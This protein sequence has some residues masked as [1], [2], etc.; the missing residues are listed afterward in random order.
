MQYVHSDLCT[1]RSS[2]EYLEKTDIYFNINTH[3]LLVG[4][5]ITYNIWLFSPVLIYSQMAGFRVR[6][7]LPYANQLIQ[8]VATTDPMYGFVQ[9][10]KPEPGHCCRV[11][12]A[13]TP[14][15]CLNTELHCCY[16]LLCCSKS[17][18]SMQERVLIAVRM[19]LFLVHLCLICYPEALSWN[20]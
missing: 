10:R 16:Y 6:I 7:F 5:I 8:L 1:F 3:H 11:S 18:E 4:N 17:S 2:Q 20:G 12:Q 13:Y 15:L 14:L 19:Y 9:H